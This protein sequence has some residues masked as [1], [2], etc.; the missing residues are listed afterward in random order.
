MSCRKRPTR[1]RAN[2]DGTANADA[3]SGGGGTAV[4][5]QIGSRHKRPGGSGERIADERDERRILDDEGWGD[6][7]AG[8]VSLCA[9]DGFDGD[10]SIVK[11]FDVILVDPGDD[12]GPAAA[13]G[14]EEHGGG[15]GPVRIVH[16][17][18]GADGAVDDYAAGF[19][20]RLFDFFGR[21]FDGLRQL[22]VT[23]HF[24]LTKDEAGR[25]AARGGDGLYAY[26]LSGAEF[27]QMEAG[28]WLRV[29]GAFA[30]LQED[31]LAGGVDERNDR[32]QA[33]LWGSAKFVSRQCS[34]S[35]ERTYEPIRLSSGG[36]TE[37]E[38]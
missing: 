29:G 9:D 3:G 18:N 30:L 10:G 26:T 25:V 22:G 5:Q 6:E 13:A 23:E 21:C 14:L 16:G 34:Q 8:A 20:D 2:G 15:V 19:V 4:L 28:T 36:Q 38:E 1:G 24:E 17:G 32:F 31:E 12:H 11:A 27:G 7:L 33:G 35:R 37:H